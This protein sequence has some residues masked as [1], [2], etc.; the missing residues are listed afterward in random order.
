[1]LTTELE[2]LDPDS[3]E[4]DGTW[5]QDVEEN[6]REVLGEIEDYLT[7][8]T[9]VFCWSFRHL[10]NIRLIQSFPIYKAYYFLAFCVVLSLFCLNTCHLYLL[11]DIPLSVPV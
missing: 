8:C 9:T 2:D 7:L 11:G 3:I 10:W 4:S 5:L 6:A 1:M